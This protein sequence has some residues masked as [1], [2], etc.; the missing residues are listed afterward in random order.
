MLSEGRGGEDG[1]ELVAEDARLEAVPDLLGR[2]LA[3]FE[4][5]L[6]ELLVALGD[7]LDEVL[8]AFLGLGLELGRDGSLP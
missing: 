3:L 4:V 5:F 2:Q 6:H 8:V 1:K 7:H